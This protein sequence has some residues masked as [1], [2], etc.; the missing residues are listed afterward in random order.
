MKLDYRSLFDLSGRVAVITGGA[1]ILGRHFGHALASFGAHV[2]VI[3]INGEAAVRL[4]D[5]IET[6][7]RVKTIG[8]DCD[9]ADE[10]QVDAMVD[11]VEAKLGPIDI[12]TNNAGTKTGEPAAF[13]APID[14][15]ELNTWREIMAVNIDGV[16]LVSRRIG[17]RM[18]A[19]GR[20][21][22]VSISSIYG[23]VGCDMRIYDGSEY[24]G[25]QISQPPAYAASKAGVIGLTRYLAT[26]WGAKGVRVNAIT[27]GG[28]RSGQNET[29]QRQY[30]SR[31][32]AGRMGEAAEMVGA[33]IYL[34]SD[35]S[36]YVTGQNLIVD[37]GLT[38]W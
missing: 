23:V 29:F 36:T 30:A 27:P 21:S 7:H 6:L 17:S 24:M 28:V 11:A 19:R 35:A 37:G 38:A 34:A 18:A 2:A 33:L 3:D 8:L 31:V 1:G 14:K 9:V 4:A 16:F 13:F 15:F 12:L 20:G 5:E 26:L 22:I 25:H 10:S 32:P